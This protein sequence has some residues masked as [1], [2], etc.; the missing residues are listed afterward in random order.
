MR[1]FTQGRRD[2]NA[3][4]WCLGSRL[5]ESSEDSFRNWH[6]GSL[7]PFKVDLCGGLKELLLPGAEGQASF[8]EVS[9]RG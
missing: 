4:G 3:G 8:C 5:S 7:Y 9:A 6:R 1:G 2:G